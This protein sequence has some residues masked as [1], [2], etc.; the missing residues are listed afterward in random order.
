MQCNSV[1]DNK[2]SLSPALKVKVSDS[3]NRFFEARVAVMGFKCRVIQLKGEL[4]QART[5]VEPVSEHRQ[6]TTSN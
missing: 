3:T 1:V 6:A 5:Q 2:G 4:D